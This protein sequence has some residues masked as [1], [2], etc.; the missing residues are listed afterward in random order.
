MDMPLSQPKNILI[1]EDE[2]LVAQNLS[3]AIKSLGYNVTGMASTAEESLNMVRE[4][5][6]DLVLMDIK[7]PGMPGTEAAKQIF[8]GMNVPV[9][10]TTAYAQQDFVNNSANAGVFGYL[11]KPITTSSLKTTIPIAWA[12]YLQHLDQNE[13]IQSLK[14][15][16]A[17]RKVIEQAKGILMQRNSL[18]EPDAFAALR[19]QAR[20][21]RRKLADMARAV[22]ETQ[23]LLEN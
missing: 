14:T 13:K 5:R 21:S 4:N 2:H 1:V 9:I 3:H 15:T 17:E 11:L 7:L 6:P 10:I 16:L 20:S 18:S 8:F 23:D 22:I 19:N 12:N